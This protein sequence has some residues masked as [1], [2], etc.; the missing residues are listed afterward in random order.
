MLLAR[1]NEGEIMKKVLYSFFAFALLASLCLTHCGGTEGTATPST[2]A[3][4]SSAANPDA[5]SVDV[6]GG[7]AVS[8]SESLAPSSSKSVSQT[9]PDNENSMIVSKEVADGVSPAVTIDDTNFAIG[10]V[11][12]SWL[13]DVTETQTKFMSQI[14]KGILFKEDDG[15]SSAL[16]TFAKKV[17]VGDKKFGP[18]EVTGPGQI[19]KFTG[20]A[21]FASFTGC[22]TDGTFHLPTSGN[23]LSITLFVGSSRSNLKQNAVVCVTSLDPLRAKVWLEGAPWFAL[24]SDGRTSPSSIRV[25]NDIDMSNTDSSCP[26]TKCRKFIT[27]MFTS[28][29]GSSQFTAVPNKFN[30]ILYMNDSNTKQFLMSNRGTFATVQSYDPC[31]RLDSWLHNVASN[32]SEIAGKVDT[33][34][35]DATITRANEGIATASCSTIA[36]NIETV[37]AASATGL[38]ANSTGTLLSTAQCSVDASFTLLD[39]QTTTTVETDTKFPSDAPTTF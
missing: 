31:I 18:L 13:L 34:R 39:D 28:G 35:G 27:K 1:K 29:G 2:P 4:I 32:G 19:G 15:D 14:T 6:V 7:T 11:D 30:G 25:F 5:P 37:S 23:P 20:A 24:F 10:R 21:D 22:S 9:V 33:R 38:C 3:Q 12:F 36:A 8:T 17:E 26:F 16:S